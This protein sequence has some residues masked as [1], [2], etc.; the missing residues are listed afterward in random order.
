MSNS[1][2]SELTGDER[3]EFPPW[4][5]RPETSSGWTG[6]YFRRDHVATASRE[7]R[8]NAIDASAR[9]VGLAGWLVRRE[10]GSVD[11]VLSGN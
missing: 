4:V 7:I 1:M 8:G 11:I 10:I 5:K 2:Q 6:K 3:G 9:S